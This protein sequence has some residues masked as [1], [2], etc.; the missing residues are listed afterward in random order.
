[1][2]ATAKALLT[3]D[4]F[5]RLPSTEGKQ[6]LVRG[7][8]VQMAPPGGEHASLQSELIY[9]LRL[10][11]ETER[12]GFVLGE[13]GFKLASDPDLVRAPDVA[14]VEAV[15]FP[16]GRLP[17]GYI[18]GPPDLAVEIVSPNDTATEVEEKVLEYLDAGAKRVWV[19]NP[20]TAAV[21]VHYPD[22]TS[23]TLRGDDVLSG[24]DVV[25]GFAVRVG[26]LFNR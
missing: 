11:A 15:R 23:R 14:F 1:M 13:A 16:G 22:R 19:V 3:A 4:E 24:E 10:S 25:P 17:A 7:K 9:R 8:V 2:T 21:T 26:D 20:T 6:E 18:D 5:F 12:Q